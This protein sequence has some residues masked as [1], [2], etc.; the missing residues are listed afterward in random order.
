M[1]C[2]HPCSITEKEVTPG[3][4]ETERQHRWAQTRRKDEMSSRF[5]FSKV[6]PGGYRAMLALEHYVHDSGLET[7]LL[8]LIKTR[9]SQINR[10]AYC[11]DMHWKNARAA[12]E[13]EQRL[14]LLD[15]WREG[16]FYSEREKAALAWTEALTSLGDGHVREDVY[17]QAR[18][19]FG[20]KELA[21]LSVAVVAINGW[22]RLLHAFPP[23]VG[24][25]QPL[26]PSV[27]LGAS[28]V[29]SDN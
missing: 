14:Y 6:A 16:P 3:L 1:R 29:I 11:I 21:D 26:G 20:E 25:Y 10:C 17:E 5:N 12:G 9:A 2:G 28:R 24:S 18:K 19:H 15:A 22:N 13:T 7:S 8:E 4:T 27:T 23:D